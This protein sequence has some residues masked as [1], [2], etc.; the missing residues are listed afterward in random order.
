MGSGGG[1]ELCLG[2]HPGHRGRRRR[3][4]R[5]VCP[6][7]GQRQGPQWR[8]WHRLLPPGQQRPPGTRRGEGG[9][10]AEVAFFQHCDRPWRPAPDAAGAEPRQFAPAA[11]ELHRHAADFERDRRSTSTSWPLPRRVAQERRRPRQW[12]P[13]RHRRDRRQLRVQQHPECGGLRLRCRRR[14]QASVREPE[15]HPAAGQRCAELRLQRLSHPSG[16]EI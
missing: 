8:R 12:W 13:E 3:C 1:A 14:A 7:P 4:V 9:R 15:L 5:H 10:G 11:G 2:L 16:Q 6:A